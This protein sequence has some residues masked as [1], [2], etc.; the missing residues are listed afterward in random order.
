MTDESSDHT[1]LTVQRIISEVAKIPPSDIRPENPVTGLTNVDSIVLIEIVA[2]TELA[3]DI[4]IDEEQLFDLN[5]V[6]DF[7]AACRRLTSADA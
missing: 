1:Y 5:T 4:E 6:G 7:V 3:L 2:R